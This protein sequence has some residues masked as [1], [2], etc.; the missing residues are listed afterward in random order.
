[1]RSVIV[2]T[3]WWSNCLA[4]ACLHRLAEFAPGREL[5]VMQAGKSGPQMEKLRALLPPGVTELHYPAHLP[6]DDSPM[7]EY[8]ARD[9]LRERDGAWFIDHDTFLLAPAAAWLE[10]ADLRFEDAGACLATAVP[11]HG[12]GL[13]QP[14]YWLSPSRW[15]GGLSSFDPIPFHVK[16]HTR[17]PDLFRHDG[18]TLSMPVKDTLV[19][20]AGELEERGLATAFPLEAGAPGAC[21]LP[22]FP[23]HRHLGGIHLY[24]GPV[25]PPRF[26]E[27]MR[28]V[29]GAFDRFFS[30]CPAEWLASEE[31]ELLRRHREF[32]DALGAGASGA[33]EGTEAE[34]SATRRPRDGR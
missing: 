27:W 26:L 9:A 17:R 6:T 28:G 14:A 16:P 31:P 34:A 4:L 24:T 5:Y 29:V 18:R 10:E 3:S 30:E 1:M 15:P 13:T 7:R 2:V 11:R 8:L 19:Q 25:L 21:A 33:D 20:V 22:A 32:R 23:R 12:P